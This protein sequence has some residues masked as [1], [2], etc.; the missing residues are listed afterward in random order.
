VH[1]L[2]QHAPKLPVSVVIPCFNEELVLPYLAN[3]LANF[4]S[5]LRE[6]YDFQ[7]LFVDD[8]S[9]DGTWNALRQ[10][11]GSRPNCHFLRHE[12]NQGAAAAILTGIRH[13]TTEIV[14]SIDCDCTYDPLELKN[15]IPMLSEGVDVV[16]ASPYHPQ[17]GVRNVPPWRLSLS[18]GAS[19]L[20]RRVLRQKLSTYTS[21][22]RVH[23]RSAVVDLNLRESGFL[24]VAEM[25][26]LLDL[27]GS[28]VAEYPTVLEV[29]MLGRSK[30]KILSNIAGHLRLLI[31]LLTLRLLHKSVTRAVS[32]P[33]VPVLTTSQDLAA[34]PIATRT[35]PD[36]SN[37][38]R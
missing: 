20:Y 36:P 9:L 1:T 5:A 7:F 11:F 25:L 21:F 29:R 23:R 31:R 30:M 13:A 17:G 33:T 27:R 38:H 12:K 3:T 10:I 37:H 16:T 2:V 14:C 19:F 18:K 32:H 24:G 4:Q 22:F 34:S 8:C 15:M 35:L 28:T 26:G 6:V